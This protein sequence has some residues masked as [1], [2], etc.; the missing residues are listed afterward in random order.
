VKRR[1]PDGAEK[2][3]EYRTEKASLP[4]HWETALYSRTVL[5][6]IFGEA[7]KEKPPEFQGVLFTMAERERFLPLR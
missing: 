2:T 1:A 5:G 6:G 4:V 3:E 7:Q